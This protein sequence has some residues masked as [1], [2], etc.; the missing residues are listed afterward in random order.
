VDI[1]DPGND[2]ALTADEA[3]AWKAIERSLRLRARYRYRLAALTSRFTAQPIAIV[4]LGMVLSGAA[5]VG[6]VT[7]PATAAL[8]AASGI[9]AVGIG[10][11]G[12]GLVRAFRPGPRPASGLSPKRRLRRSIGGAVPGATPVAG[13]RSRGVAGHSGGGLGRTGGDLGRTGGG[14]GRTGGGFGQRVR[15]RLRFRRIGS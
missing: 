8:V 11:L 15:A 7:L 14:L 6:A 3:Q 13:A 5:L 4:G 10:L 1:R 12:F 9:S 2:H